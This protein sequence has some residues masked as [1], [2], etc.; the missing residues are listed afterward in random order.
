MLLAPTLVL[1]VLCVV[2]GLTTDLTVGVAGEAVR[3]L[4]GLP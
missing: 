1:S 2:F 4:G 3:V